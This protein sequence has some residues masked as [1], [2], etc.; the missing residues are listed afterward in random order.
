MVSPRSRPRIQVS[1]TAKLA[2]KVELQN[3]LSGQAGFCISRYDIC[4]SLRWRGEGEEWELWKT[5][6]AGFLRLR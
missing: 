2:P 5:V 3:G 4:I 1:A 6:L